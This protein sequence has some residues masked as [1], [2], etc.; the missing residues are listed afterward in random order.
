MRDSKSAHP[1][2]FLGSLAATAQSSPGRQRRPR[3]LRPLR[4]ASNVSIH[5][6]IRI[7]WIYIWILHMVKYLNFEIRVFIS[8]HFLLDSEILQLYLIINFM[9]NNKISS[10]EG[11]KG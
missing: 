1:E 9:T 7:L 4:K 11:P 5:F 6:R 3:N 10:T 2:G 8:Q